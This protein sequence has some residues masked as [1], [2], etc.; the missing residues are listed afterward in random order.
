MV[1]VAVGAK[2]GCGGSGCGWGVGVGVAVAVVGDCGH[3][4]TNFVENG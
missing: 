3:F 1:W 2:G 4:E